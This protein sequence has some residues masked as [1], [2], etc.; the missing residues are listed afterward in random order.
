MHINHKRK[1]RIAPTHIEWKRQQPEKENSGFRIEI[2]DS[3]L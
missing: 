1:L 3:Y 2:M